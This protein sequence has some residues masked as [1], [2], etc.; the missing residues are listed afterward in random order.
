M[1]VACL[2]FSQSAPVQKVAENCLRFSPQI[3]FRR[4]HAV[5]IEIG[6]CHHLYSEEGF[7]ARLHVILRR[8]NLK[9]SCAIGQDIPDS[10]LMAQF[11]QKDLLSLPLAALLDLADPFDRDPVM[12]KY[13][14][15]MISSFQDLGLRT[16][17]QF[18]KIPTAELT[19]RFGQ[20]GILCQQ[21][22]R[23]DFTLPWP[24]WAPEEILFEKSE[25]PYFE[26]YGELEPLLFE[27]KK[28]L[29]LLFQRLWA[30]ALKAQSL[31]VKVFCEKTYSN[32]DPC[33]SFH[34]DFLLPQS[35]TKG[36]LS[37]L[38]ERLSRDFQ[39]A[40]IRSPIE[41]LE[42][43]VTSTAPGG[44]GQKNFL[45]HR[46]ETA[47]Q[48][49][50]LLSQ[51][52]E[53]HGK[54]NI[55]QAELT[56]ER[57]PEKSWRKSLPISFAENPAAVCI[58]GRLPLRPTHLLTPERIQILEGL[59]FIREK[60]FKIIKWTENVERLSGDWLANDQDFFT[61]SYDRDYYQVE[62]ENGILVSIFQTPRQDF[63]LQGYF[64]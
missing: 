38:K 54:E 43:R 37:I 24:A 47:E 55:F 4:D 9:A 40:P 31:Q 23:G 51:L 58:E 33:R 22:L 61:P 60:P 15:K 59:M 64:G 25:F 20:I 48:L 56:E 3:C 16:L 32:P 50:S 2:W 17:R 28:H 6:K 63:Y 49:H 44:M 45:H 30:R 26:F 53:T 29:D 35:S 10:L 39:R 27:L 46:E 14:S 62:L 18:Q 12:R 34:F 13:I 52:C 5:F 19:T 21:R 1:R 41:G 8:M 11:A 57:L 36:A 7:L 42:T